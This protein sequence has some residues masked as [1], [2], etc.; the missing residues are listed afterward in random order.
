MKETDGATFPGSSRSLFLIFIP[1]LTTTF[2]TSMLLIPVFLFWLFGIKVR[3][4]EIEIS[5]P[6]MVSLDFRHFISSFKS[7]ISINKF[8]VN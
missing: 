7:K 5:L 3:N 6:M 4:L 1:S 8:R 2:H